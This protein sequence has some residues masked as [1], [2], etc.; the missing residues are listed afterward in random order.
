MTTSG[1]LVRFELKPGQEEAFDALV[2]RTV[3]GIKRHEPGTL[4]YSTHTVDGSPLSRVFFELYVDQAAHASHELTE[5]TRRFLA[6]RDKY[7]ES[8]DVLRLDTVATTVEFR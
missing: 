1:L 7:V 6:E 5:H 3:N 4:V 8:Y 2:A